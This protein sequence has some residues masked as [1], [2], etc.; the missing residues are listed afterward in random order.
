MLTVYAVLCLIGSAVSLILAF[1]VLPRVPTTIVPR[2]VIWA[3]S[4]CLV[5]F[6]IALLILAMLALET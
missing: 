5:A 4:A 6:A 1:Y 3:D 2:V